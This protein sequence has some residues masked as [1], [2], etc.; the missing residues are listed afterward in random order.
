[1]R[2]F[3]RL[4]LAAALA[5]VV[6]GAAQAV[7]A[8]L[9]VHVQDNSGVAVDSVTVAAIQWGMNG[10]STYTLVG[11]TNSAGNAT[12]NLELQMGYSIY[13]SSHGWSPSI[14]D[15]FN[16]PDYDSNR[17]MW[18]W[19]A[20]PIY[21][22]FTLTHNLS[23]VGMITQSF[24]NATPNKVLFGGLHNMIS[25]MQGASGLVMTDGAGA[26]TLIVENVPFALANT[27]NI[28]L[29]DPEKNKGIGRNVM[30]DLGDGGV[31]PG[32]ELIAYTGGATLNFDQSIPPSRVENNTRPGDG[33]ASGA[34]VEGVLV[35]TNGTAI[36]HMGLGIRACVGNQ[37]DNWAHADENGRFQ[38]Y[39]L[40]PGVTYYIQAMGGCTWSNNGQDNKCYEPFS[41]PN[42][43]A[44]DICTANNSLATSND[45]V[46][47][48]SDV[49]YHSITL[50]EMPPSI[51]VIKVCVKS[52]D[53]DPIP[54]ANVGLNPDGSPWST[55]NCVS[56]NW[57]P[58]PD[59][60]SNQGFSNTNVNTGADGCATLTGLPSGN[61]MVNAWTPFSGGMPV[62]FNAGADETWTAFG[63]NGGGDWQQAHCQG[64]GVDDY[65]VT[66]DTSNAQTMYVFDS[67]GTV[68]KDGAGVD[69]SSIT[70]MVSV[71]G[72]DSGEVKGTLTFPGSVNLANTP[73]VIT[74]YG[75]CMDMNTPC[76][77]GNFKSVTGSG[78]TIPYT[79]N[80]SSGFSYWMNVKG[81][82]WGRVQ[83]G[84]GDNS[85]HLQT[86]SSAIVNMEFAPAG[87]LRGTVYKP[88]TSI[89]TPASNQWVW[90]DAGNDSG[91]TGTQLQKDGT[92]EM[93]DVLAGVN[94]ISINVSGDGGFNYAVPSPRPT[95]NVVA[96]TTSTLNINLVNANYVGIDFDPSKTPDSSVV[97]NNHDSIIG[98]KVMPVTAGT[99]IKGETIAEML[100]GKGDDQG[101]FRYSSGTVMGHEGPCGQNWP[102]GFC[103]AS[104]PSPAVYDF[105][106]MRSGD[107]GDPSE[108]AGG[109]M[110]YPHFVL[111]SSTKNVIVSNEKATAQVWPPYSQS[112]S[113]GVLVNLTPATD[114]SA[115]G[116]A[117]L[118][119]T[120]TAD[121]FFRQA[122]YDSLGGDF[123]AFIEYLPVVSLYDS[124]GAFK[125]AGIVL[126]PPDFIAQKEQAGEFESAF[127]GGYTQFITMLNE[128][129]A[130]GFQI[131][132][133]APSACYTAVM[134]TPN[135][136]PYQTRTCV[137]V[138]GSTTT[139]SVDLDSAVGTGATVRGV[140]TS[141]AAVPVILPNVTVTL[142]G[143]AAGSRTAITDSSGAYTFE[144][145]AP[146]SVRLKVSVDGYAAG[147][148]QADL[149]GSNTYT[150][151]FALTAAGGSITG[152]VYS[153]KLPYAKVQAGAS[154]LAYNDTYNGTH[155]DSPLPLI[156]TQ[157]GADGTYRLTGLIPGDVYKVFLKVPGKYTL[158]QTTTTISGNLAGIDFTMLPKPLDI[159]VFAKKGDVYFE[160]TV[161]NPQDFKD[162]WVGWSASPFNPVSASTV[163]MTQLSSGELSGKIP[164]SAL[165]PDTTYVLYGAAR[166]YSGKRVVRE[167]LFGK[168]YKGNTRQNIDD[169]ILGDD[170]ENDTGRKNNEL[171]MDKSGDN[172]SG[173]T[174]PPGAMLP[175]SG[176]IP[177]CSFKAEDAGA[178]SVADKVAALGADAF[179]GDVYTIELTSATHNDN[180]SIELTLAYDKTTAD[181]DDLSVARYNDT[182][183]AW[184]EVPAVATIN[185]L[186]GTVKVKLKT[187]ASVLSVRPGAA[188]VNHFDGRQYR[189]S[190]AGSGSSSGTFAVIRPSVAG[191]SFSGSKMKVFNYP[192]PFSLKSKTVTAHNHDAGNLGTLTTN[193]TF[194]HVEVPAANSGACHIRIYTLAGELVNKLTGSCVGGKYNYFEWNGH[195]KAGQEVANG[196]YYGVVQLSGK[197]PDLEDATFKMV[198]IK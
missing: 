184:E 178:A 132:G 129:P 168:N 154:I 172:P 20:T 127:A 56:H 163:T 196:V 124:N 47:V 93:T 43:T 114:M 16:N 140:V 63:M 188:Q 6:P 36:P 68:V 22:T 66:V 123:D 189:V 14:T 197:K 98:F 143:E 136:P 97:S 50:N 19:D 17:H 177:T 113:N 118:Q 26:G 155:P 195:N 35:S 128:A 70:Y 101:E 34:S 183:S 169:L 111:L 190:A 53:G 198:V 75:Q 85:I 11:M 179:A 191:D 9:T 67:S 30:S 159:E 3:I 119:G 141:T 21:S 91:W 116:N 149:V 194:I 117:T 48:S 102:G 180:K 148:G 32:T 42:Y 145:L 92:F 138:N 100:F 115:R 2:S 82:G 76:P 158:N 142:S 103:A 105:Y 162:G 164:L 18:P 121:N 175:S 23:G 25:Q 79:I 134:T 5:A 37:W 74:L 131:R 61:Y 15:Q 173:I 107:F 108:N 60:V 51:G 10:P 54:N 45:I 176:T 46:Y 41:S 153:Q 130:F 62:P 83:R 150:K 31:N 59:D 73:I 157:T 12:F 133:L 181:L 187:L 170:S 24:I 137:G 94:R 29:Y 44:Q 28:G 86:S 161:L 4:I 58:P 80:V 139:L 40:T 120:V 109:D 186:K 55:V 39:G 135:Y 69:L 52:S 87:T 185:P 1:M 174:F 8:P 38:I 156:K 95:V 110:P 27:Y 49:M 84:G 152:T 122:D 182:T 165:A 104:L 81:L 192:N 71:G 160:F 99:V 33:T 112:S 126:P 106:L 144:G 171:A 77:A 125:A 78:Q 96:G 193:G 167:L 89:F 64:T 166:S 65:R 13:V 72:N 90:V 88:D 57:G 147:E 151:N 146:G 7:L